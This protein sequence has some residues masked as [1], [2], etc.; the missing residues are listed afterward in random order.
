[1]KKRLG[2]TFIELIVVFGA[3]AILLSIASISSVRSR[4]IISIDSIV[5]GLINDIKLQQFYSLSEYHQ[6]GV[7]NPYYGIYFEPNRYTLFH[8]ENYQIN[9]PNNFIINLEA[10]SVFQ[11]INLPD[12]QIVFA[13]TS[14]TI[15]NFDPNLNSIVL[16][17]IKNNLQ[18]SI[19]LNKYGA[20][21]SI[22]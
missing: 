19:Y 13:S 3:M 2:L 1:M 18:K 6:G 17:N 10:D 4:N 21:Y 14:G 15:N 20:I 5:S 8:T 7:Q 16:R 22:E 9:D 11:S 12:N